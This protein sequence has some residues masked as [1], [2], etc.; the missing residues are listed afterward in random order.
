VTPPPARAWRV[1]PWDRDAAPG[2]PFSPEYVPQ[3]QGKGRFDL[4]GV[5]GGVL[6]AA[7]TAEHAVAELVQQYRGQTL[8]EADLIVAGRRLAVVAVALPG[9][10]R[11]GVLDLCDPEELVRLG[12]RPDETASRDRR[13]TQRI[14]AAV[15]AAGH[16][17]LRWWSAFS[18]D[19]HTVMLFRDRLTA[20]PAFETPEALTLDHPALREA[21]RELGIAVAAPAGARTRAPAR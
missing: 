8:D 5:P 14:G 7:E 16:T 20:P 1:F 4:P 11:R 12:V 15:H 10:V 19:W 3:G 6:Y 13:A 9:A 2:E 21:A 18:G 17:G